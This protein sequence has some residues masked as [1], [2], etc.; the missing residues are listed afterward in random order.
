MIVLIVWLLLLLLMLRD[1]LS[2]RLVMLLLLLIRG[3]WLD[4]VARMRA[5]F[6]GKSIDHDVHV[7]AK[8]APIGSVAMRGC[9]L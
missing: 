3:D 8:T 2:H 5:I 6:G 9:L 4:Q 7:A 1:D